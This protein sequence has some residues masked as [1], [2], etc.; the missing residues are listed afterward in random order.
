MIFVCI[1]IVAARERDKQD[2]GMFWS[3]LEP[4]YCTYGLQHLVS[5]PLLFP[6][7]KDSFLWVM[8][9]RRAAAFVKLGKGSQALPR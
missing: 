9:F 5:G 3:L 2:E 8:V 6:V 1:V 7:P 4:P